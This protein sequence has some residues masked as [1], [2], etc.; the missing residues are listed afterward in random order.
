M[1]ILTSSWHPISQLHFGM[2]PRSEASRISI[3]PSWILILFGTFLCP[4]GPLV[5][6][7]ISLKSRPL[8][9]HMFNRLAKDIGHTSL[10]HWRSGQFT[11]LQCLRVF[12]H[13]WRGFDMFWWLVSDLGLLLCL[14]T[15]TSH[16]SPSGRAPAPC[17]EDWTVECGRQVQQ[18]GWRNHQK[19][20]SY[21][22]VALPGK[23]KL[24]LRSRTLV[25]VTSR[26]AMWIPVFSKSVLA[27]W[28]RFENR[29]YT[30]NPHWSHPKLL[31]S[32]QGASQD[33]YHSLYCLWYPLV[34]FEHGCQIYSASCSTWDYTNLSNRLPALAD[35]TCL[36]Y[37]TLR[38]KRRN[39]GLRR[40]FQIKKSCEESVIFQNIVDA[41]KKFQVNLRCCQRS[42]YPEASRQ[43]SDVLSLELGHPTDWA[44]SGWPLWVTQPRVRIRSDHLG[45]WQFFQ[46]ITNLQD[47]LKLIPRQ[48]C[49]ECV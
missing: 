25:I 42:E 17:E 43:F 48:K 30:C 4:I 34:F 19:M 1:G 2:W 23:R 8:A 35:L 14:N 44:P 15:L 28:L 37:T 29:F 20:P 3:R 41:S 22:S 26:L 32:Y 47:P 21:W 5:L 6:P 36:S 39:Q 38:S 40:P 10:K 45:K 18:V 9:S 7:A 33:L 16:T 24:Q 11:R 27:R 49:S 46:G 31:L 12:R 13:V